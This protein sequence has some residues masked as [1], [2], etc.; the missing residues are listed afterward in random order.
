M[1]IKQLQELMT[2]YTQ[3]LASERITFAYAYH[4]DRVNNTGTLDFF[5]VIS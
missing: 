3:L 5:Y 1:S 4:P 2:Y